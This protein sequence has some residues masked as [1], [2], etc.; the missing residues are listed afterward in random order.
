MRERVYPGSEIEIIE[1]LRPGNS[2]TR[3]LTSYE[4]EG[5]NIL[6]LLTIPNGPKP[7]SGWPVIIFN[8]G[9]IPPEVYRTAE[10]YVAYVDWL[11]RSGYIVFM[12]DYRGHGDS[13]GNARGAYGRPDYTIDVINA[14]S[15]M[16]HFSEADPNRIGMWGHS[17]GGYITL[18]SMVIRDDI[19]AGVIWAGV[20]GSYPDLFN[21]GTRTPVPN[22]TP[23]F[24]SRWRDELIATYGSP[25]DNPEFW[26]MISANAYLGD[27][28][29]PIQLHH[30]T[31]D[32]TVPLVNSEILSQQIRAAGKTVEFY[33]YEGDDHNLANFFSLAM[34][35][36]IQF[37]DAHLKES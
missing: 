6:A 2:Y 35:R 34:Q 24:P 20:V 7:S 21:R 10:R 19:K 1:P 25:E 16:Q 15:A 13:E 11:A 23:R 37:F 26:N 5:L 29:G 9:Y 4:S 8:H 3:Y 14:V 30:G 27:L 33:V 18:R 17:M 31:G 36:T 32:A 22:A 28:S 12:P